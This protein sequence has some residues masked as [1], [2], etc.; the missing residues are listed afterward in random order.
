MSLP[1]QVA[2]GIAAAKEHG[3]ILDITNSDLTHMQSHRLS[4][5]KALRLDD[6]ITGSDMTRPGFLAFIGGAKEDRSISHVFFYKRDR[7][8]RPADAFTASSL[9]KDLLLAGI[10]I[11]LSDGIALPIHSGE[12]CLMR[13]ME[14]LFAYSQNGE[15]IRKLSERVLGFQRTLA[16]GGY[17]TGGNAPYGFV[18]VLVD[19][20]GNIQEELPRGKVVRQMNFHVRVIP[21]DPEKIAIWI[22]ILDWKKQ[23]WGF[24]RIA[25]ELNDRGIPSPDAG[26]TRT[27]HDIRP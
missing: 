26:R 23:G 18:R 19:S 4:S 12:Q 7:F 11:I 24:K 5:Y 22:Q 8:A 1:A 20:N 6:G 21:K 15:E 13:D 25:K 2:W 10:T 16:E 9:E 17:R 27:D 3:V 14:M